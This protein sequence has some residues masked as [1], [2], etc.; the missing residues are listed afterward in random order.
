MKIDPKQ[1]KRGPDGSY[2][3]EVTPTRFTFASEQARSTR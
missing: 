1:M 3:G 2:T